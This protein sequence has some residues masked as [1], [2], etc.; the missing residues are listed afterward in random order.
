MLEVDTHRYGWVWNRRPRGFGQWVFEVRAS[1]RSFGSNGQFESAP[2][3]Y[4]DA[5]REARKWARKTFGDAAFG[6]VLL[7]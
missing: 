6:L 1:R 2:M 4:T 3:Y 7:P 5:V